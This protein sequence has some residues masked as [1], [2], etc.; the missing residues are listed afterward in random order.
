MQAITNFDDYVTNCLME[1]IKS[2]RL[3]KVSSFITHFGDAK[4]HAPLFAF[5]YISG[6]D[7]V[8]MLAVKVFI[9]TVIGAALLYLMRITFKRPRPIGDVPPEYVLIPKLEVYSFPSGHAMRNFIFPVIFYNMFGIVPA[10]ALAAFASAITIAR[11]YLR[12][13][14]FSDIVCGA[15]LG[16]ISGYIALGLT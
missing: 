9:A 6:N 16:G 12:L 5:L 1:R 4:Y 10:L 14:Y 13:H 11:V 15:I 3:N 7:T 2:P 8:K